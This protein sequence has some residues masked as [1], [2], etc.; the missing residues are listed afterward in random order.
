MSQPTRV[1]EVCVRSKR[2]V[3]TKRDTGTETPSLT[4]STLR[5]ALCTDLNERSRCATTGAY[6]R[7][8][9]CEEQVH[10]KQ[11]QDDAV[12]MVETHDGRCDE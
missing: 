9:R 1:G 3:R 11:R 8:R 12:R 4:N 10:D 5:R 2:A 6:R 7:I